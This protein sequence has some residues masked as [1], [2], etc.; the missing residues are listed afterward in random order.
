MINNN[1]DESRGAAPARPAVGNVPWERGG[2][3][4]G[5]EGKDPSLLHKQA[6]CE[7]RVSN[8]EGR[9]FFLQQNT[10]A[11]RFFSPLP[12]PLPPPPP[13]EPRFFSQPSITFTFPRFLLFFRRTEEG[14]WGVINISTP[15][16]S[17]VLGA[18]FVLK[19]SLL[20]K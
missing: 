20:S 9:V 5:G 7:F 4:G 18:E 12:P 3:G 11:F 2:G 10:S 14:K 13:R 6:G 19:R 8:M 17:K 15:S 16:H 1:C